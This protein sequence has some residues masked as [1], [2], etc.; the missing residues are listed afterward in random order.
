[1]DKS[2]LPNTKVLVTLSWIICL[3]ASLN[4]CYDFFIRAAPSVM[5]NNLIIDFGICHS[6]L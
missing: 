3:I 1:M 6:E 5:G 4:Y 2:Q